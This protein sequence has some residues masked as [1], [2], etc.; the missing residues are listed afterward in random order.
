MLILGTFSSLAQAQG[1]ITFS[2]PGLSFSI[3]DGYRS[4]PRYYNPPPVYY[5]PPVYRAP[6][7]TP[8]VTTYYNGNSSFNA[9]TYYAPPPVVYSPP[10]YA[11]P[12]YPAYPPTYYAPRHNHYNRW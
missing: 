4:A 3:N 2:Q 10:V 5:A 11:A 7:Y 1:S 8:P 9:P 12:V 6:V